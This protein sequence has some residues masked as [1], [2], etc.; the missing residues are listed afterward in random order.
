MLIEDGKASNEVK[1]GSE[2][3]KKSEL[4]F[5]EFDEEFQIQQARKKKGSH[6]FFRKD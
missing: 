4:D 2:G 5:D 3:S 1:K 6:L